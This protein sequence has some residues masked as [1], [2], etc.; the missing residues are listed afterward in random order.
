MKFLKLTFIS[1]MISLSFVSCSKAGDDTQKKDALGAI[2]ASSQNKGDLRYGYCASAVTIMNQCVGSN[3]GFS[4]SANCDAAHLSDTTTVVGTT[5]S[6][7][8]TG[9]VTT[10]SVYRDPSLANYE[11]L[12]SCV[13][14][15]VK[16]TY[17]NLPQNRVVDARIAYTNFFSSCDSGKL[18]NTGLR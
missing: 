5:S 7:S 9:V 1:C 14:A 11:A 15:A 8:A 18:V 17:C 16:S 12:I 3:N 6:T 10:T 13:S 2:L 4:Y